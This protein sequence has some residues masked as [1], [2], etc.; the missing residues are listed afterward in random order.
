[1]LREGELRFFL[2]VGEGIAAE[3]DVGAA[4]VKQLDPVGEQT[5]RGGVERVGAHE[6]GEMDRFRRVVPGGEVGGVAALA[7]L[8]A[9]GGTVGEDEAVAVADHGLV[10]DGGDGLG[11]VDGDAVAVEEGEGLAAVLGNGEGGVALV[12][13]SGIAPDD[14]VAA[15]GENR[16]LRED[17]LHQAAVVGETA[18]GEVDLRPSR[19]EQ[20]DEVGVG[21]VGGG[22]GA[23]GGEDLAD[24]DRV[25]AR[26]RRAAAQHRRSRDGRREQRDH[27]RPP[28]YLV[29]DSVSHRSVSS[30]R[31][32]H[33]RKIVFLFRGADMQIAAKIVDHF[34]VPP[35]L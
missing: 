31:S 8:E 25:A 22:I 14:E 1:M 16:A 10:S 33:A 11:A 6:L 3:V 34:F 2:R 20:L 19:V 24:A 35:R 5:V 30:K 17:V 7:V 29:S 18:A 13:R 26:R 12:R 28:Q 32:I 23:V 9:G 4:A 21:A 15:G 27:R